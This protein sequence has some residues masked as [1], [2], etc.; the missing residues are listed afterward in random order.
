MLSLCQEL[1]CFVSLFTFKWNVFW[2]MKSNILNINMRW[3]YWS[4]KRKIKHR[5]YK[6]LRVLKCGINADSILCRLL[7]VSLLLSSVFWRFSWDCLF[8]LKE[9]SWHIRCQ[10]LKNLWSGTE[11]CFLLKVLYTQAFFSWCG[12]W[13]YLWIMH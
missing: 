5:I 11:G 13:D 1:M 10:L 9:F 6:Y 8:L 4:S 7:I 3:N 12:S 2:R